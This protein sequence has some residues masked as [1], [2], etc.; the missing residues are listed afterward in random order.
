MKACIILHNMIVKDGRDNN[1]YHFMP[2]FES[3]ATPVDSSYVNS[4]PDY[5]ES[6]IEKHTQ[7]RN[8]QSHKQLLSDLVEH[9][10]EKF[11]NPDDADMDN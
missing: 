3:G 9:I 2:D 7:V 6:Y 5:M 1:N 4:R 11:G 8:K 10:W